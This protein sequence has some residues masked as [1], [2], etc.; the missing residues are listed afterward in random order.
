VRTRNLAAAFCDF[1]TAGLFLWCWLRPQAWRPQLAADLAVLVLLEL[2]VL[3]ATMNI[4]KYYY[5]PAG[6]SEAEEYEIKHGIPMAAPVVL[7]LMTGTLFYCGTWLAAAFL[8][9]T[10]GARFLTFS[11]VKDVPEAELRRQASLWRFDWACIAGLVFL[12][13][14]IGIP[15]PQLGMTLPASEYGINIPAGWRI[16]REPQA[17]IA[18]GFVYFALTGL[19]LL[20]SRPPKSA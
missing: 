11:G 16:A 10:V 3:Y 12:I 9:L 4:G 15:V 20:L 18:V 6:L 7:V 17:P 5:P 13:M 19:A 1:A 8:L 2:F 14:L